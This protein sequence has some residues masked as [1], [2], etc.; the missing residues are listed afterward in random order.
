[1]QEGKKQDSARFI[2]L[3]GI[4]KILLLPFMDEKKET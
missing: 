3:E 2:D 1:M 4:L